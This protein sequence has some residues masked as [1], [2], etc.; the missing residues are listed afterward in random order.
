MI[1]WRAISIPELGALAPADRPL[2]W[3]LLKR[4]FGT[5]RVGLS[6]LAMFFAVFALAAWLPPRL[7]VRDWRLALVIAVVVDLLALAVLAVV[8]QQL[9]RARLRAQASPAA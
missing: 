4:R 8:Q 3:R 9:I 7:G 1:Y 6:L 5:T 2:A